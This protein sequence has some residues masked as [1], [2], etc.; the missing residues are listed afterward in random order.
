MNDAP[1]PLLSVSPDAYLSWYAVRLSSCASRALKSIESRFPTVHTKATRFVV[2]V[3]GNATV[4][5]ALLSVAAVAAFAILAGSCFFGIPFGPALIVLDCIAGGTVAVCVGLWWWVNPAKA[6]RDHAELMATV[7]DEL[8]SI[9]EAS[10]VFDGINDADLEHMRPA[11][12]RADKDT[13]LT[14]TRFDPVID[15]ACRNEYDTIA[16]ATAAGALQK[17]LLGS[18]DKVAAWKHVFP[19][20]EKNLCWTRG[21]I[22]FPKILAAAVS[23]CRQCS[24]VDAKQIHGQVLSLLFKETHYGDDASQGSNAAFDFLLLNSTPGMREDART[25]FE[26]RD[27][28]DVNVGEKLDALHSF[29]TGGT[30]TS[31]QFRMRFNSSARKI[32]LKNSTRSMD[33]DE[34]FERAHYPDG[35][36]LHHEFGYD[37][38]AEHP[39][40]MEKE[41]AALEEQFDNVD[42]PVAVTS[43]FT[44]TGT[45]RTAKALIR[46]CLRHSPKDVA[47]RLIR[48][49]CKCP[50][51][52]DNDSQWSQTYTLVFISRMPH[53][54]REKLAV[55]LGRTD[56]EIL[57]MRKTWLAEEELALKRKAKP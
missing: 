54:Y 20:L 17:I 39:D 41:V 55:A 38:F 21:C 35:C 34:C 3:F 18:P 31:T 5:D 56:A 2:A 14:W 25:C 30:I 23:I 46:N 22:G 16:G 49:I 24:P 52:T 13:D 51:T 1:P 28:N 43:Y 44:D 7:A 27:F 40:A 29:L 53:E 32:L 47:L 45:S 10:A 57:E 26:I 37:I 15:A 11:F 4:I 42:G 9:W 19:L 48:L 50:Y 12:V 6:A 33:F 36:V 8:N